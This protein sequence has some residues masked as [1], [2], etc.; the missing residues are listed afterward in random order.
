[1]TALGKEMTPGSS[2]PH[3]LDSNCLLS[4]SLCLIL[5]SLCIDEKTGTWRFYVNIP[6]SLIAKNKQQE[7]QPWVLCK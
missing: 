4:F 6:E 1:M 3:Q 5:A 7:T 2:C